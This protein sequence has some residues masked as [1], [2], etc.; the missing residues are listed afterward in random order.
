MILDI[1]KGGESG[2]YM[3][4]VHFSF[5]LG[6]FLAP[7]LATPFLSKSTANTTNSSNSTYMTSSLQEFESGSEEQS[8]MYTVYPLLGS[9]IA[10]VSLGFLFFGITSVRKSARDQTKDKIDEESEQKFTPTYAAFLALIF[11]FFFLYV[12]IEVVYIKF[13][14][15]FV[16]ET[17]M[18]TKQI[19]A[20]V[21]AI[22][23]AGFAAMR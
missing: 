21:T 10:V 7:V 2:P 23:G 22:H 14:T 19:G 16:V 17:G 4:S 12:G 1:W 3:H 9:A 20:G 5:G 15:T 13:L 8:G 11:T 18:G 6:A